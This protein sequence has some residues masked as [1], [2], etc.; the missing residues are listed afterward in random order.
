MVCRELDGK[1]GRLER[2]V[3]VCVRARVGLGLPD[4]KKVDNALK[5]T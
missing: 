2:R 1:V 4:A 3:T 5:N